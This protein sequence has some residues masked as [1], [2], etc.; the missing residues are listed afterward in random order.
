MQHKSPH[1]VRPRVACFGIGALL[2]VIQALTPPA[3]HASAGSGADWFI[4]SWPPVVSLVLTLI[5]LLYTRGVMVLWNRSGVGKG[6]AFWRVILFG[7]GLLTVVMALH[8]PIAFWSEAAL[9]VHMVQHLILLLIAP[10]LLGAGAPLFAMLWALPAGWRRS[11]ARPWRRARSLRRA[12]DAVSQP[13]VVWAL[14]AMVLWI[15]HIPTL[16]DAALQRPLVHDLQ[17]LAFV[18]AAGL[19]W[20]V[21]LNPMGRLRLNRGAGVLYVFTTSLHATALGVFITL[22]PTPWYGHYQTGSVPFG[23]TALED[24]QLAGVL[25]WMPACLVYIAL[26]ALLLLL[27]LRESERGAQRLESFTRT[28]RPDKRN[29]MLQQAEDEGV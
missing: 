23:L 7:C 9:S 13:L 25:M 17:H 24:Q 12:W 2:V 1:P 22:S 15:W 19:L 21:L 27:W 18:G 3:A 28:A 4:W 8:A 16:Y 14:Y 11:L 10:P 20:W 29:I 26:A 6:I 5:V